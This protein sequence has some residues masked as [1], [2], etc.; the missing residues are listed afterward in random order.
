M[1]VLRTLEQGR[2]LS[3][4]ENFLYSIYGSIHRDRQWLHD[5]ENSQPARN[6]LLRSCCA[7]MEGILI[8]GKSI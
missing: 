4:T 2:P 8:T 3:F 1:A 5:F 7:I 6:R